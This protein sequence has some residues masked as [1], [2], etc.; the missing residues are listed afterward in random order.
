L[1]VFRARVISGTDGE[2]EMMQTRMEAGNM[3]PAS[4]QP[5]I[6]DPFSVILYVELWSIS[7]AV[8]GPEPL[9]NSESPP[10]FS[11]L[12]PFEDPAE[13]DP[14]YGFHPRLRRFGEAA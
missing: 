12:L 6:H 5:S 3:V 13:R 4:P 9:T 10:T 11:D 8:D 14:Y 2:F 7:I 1:I